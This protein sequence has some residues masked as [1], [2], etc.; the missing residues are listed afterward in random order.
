MN[1]TACTVLFRT[2]AALLAA[3]AFG[4]A[5]A[6]AKAPERAPEPDAIAAIVAAVRT[7]ERNLVSVEL[8]LETSGRFGSGD[9]FTTRGTLHVL[10]TGQ[11]RQRTEVEFQAVGLKGRSISVRTP[12]GVTL[13]QDDPAFGELLARIPQA[14]VAD[15]EWAGLVLDRNDLPGMADARAQ[16]P[17]GSTVLAELARQFALQV[18]ERK[19]R[20]GEAG[21]WLHGER[22]PGLPEAEAVVPEATRAAAFVR[23]RDQAVLEVVYHQQDKVLQ[24]IDVKRCVVDGAIADSVFV[25]APPG[26]KVRELAA[27][28]SLQ[29]P[30]ERTLQQ[31]ER[32][33]SEK[34]GAPVLR[35]SRR[36]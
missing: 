24:R 20:G 36:Q 2:T 27:V 18:G 17:L 11:P 30:I 19:E 16:A 9:E 5:Q 15:L 28:P 33:A 14:V 23:D 3:S 12:D 10:R 1:R 29:E 6:P 35:P 4:L 22:R 13:H 26:L 25:L 7:A 8:A 31:A 34:A 21:R 32:K